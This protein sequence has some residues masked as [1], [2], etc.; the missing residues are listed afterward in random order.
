MARRNPQPIA[1]QKRGTEEFEES[2]GIRELD[3]ELRRIVGKQYEGYTSNQKEMARYFYREKQRFFYAGNVGLPKPTVESDDPFEREKVPN[4]YAGKRFT[5]EDFG[6]MIRDVAPLYKTEDTTAE[7]LVSR[8]RNREIN[9]QLFDERVSPKDGMVLDQ[10]LRPGDDEVF[11]GFAEREKGFYRRERDKIMEATPSEMEVEEFSEYVKRLDRVEELNPESPK[12]RQAMSGGGE[13]GESGRVRVTADEKKKMTLREYFAYEASQKSANTSKAVTSQVRQLEE[14]ID[15]KTKTPV[16]DMIVGDIDIGQVMGDVIS[17]SPFRDADI[18]A[19]QYRS[20]SSGLITRLNT[21]WSGAG[22]G[23]GYVATAVKDYLGTEDFE[24]ESGWRFKRGRKTPTQFPPDV[25]QQL[26]GILVD[27][28]IPY[29]ARL[30]LGGHLL[31]GLRPENIGSFTVKG[32]DKKNGLM[33]FY[34]AK[35]KKNKIIVLN[36]LAVDVINEAIRIQGD[37]IGPDGKIFPNKAKNQ[38][39]LNIVLKDRL[40]QV[41]FIR[42]DGSITPEDFTVYKLRNMHETLLTD[43]GGLE[44]GDVNFLNGRANANEAAGYV[45]EAARKR[46][47]DAA[48]KRV[49][50]AISGYMGAPSTAQL[51][52]NLNLQIGNKTKNIVVSADLLT[53]P[54]FVEAIPNSDKFIA[55]ISPDHGEGSYPKGQAPD[56][57]PRVTEAFNLEQIAASEDRAEGYRIATLEKRKRRIELE[58]EVDKI[59]EE[60]IR[61]QVRDQAEKKRIRDDEKAKLA[62][63]LDLSPEMD[64]AQKE[65]WRRLGVRVDPKTPAEDAPDAKP[66]LLGKAG[67][68]LKSINLPVVGEMTGLA[69]LTGS[70]IYGLSKPEPAF[71]MPPETGGMF[72]ETYP[73]SFQPVPAKKQAQYAGEVAEAIFSPL[74]M[75]AREMYE[76]REASEQVDIEAGTRMSMFPDSPRENKKAAPAPDDSF[77]TMSP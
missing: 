55:G 65:K 32:Y 4:P 45:S 28:E 18:E 34:D 63:N 38:R 23:Q 57:D 50:G 1:Q 52:A 72:E 12:F 30:Q 2:R 41:T 37:K 49:V 15:P 69:A 61:K 74:P 42:P 6:R 53:D 43:V 58:K 13:A 16:L 17:D 54:E 73:E 44:E 60:A 77:L 31:G 39:A 62:G 25:Y 24:T 67:K 46:R 20:R 35:S 11:P 21:M 66:G 7:G 3:K 8:K 14:I 64:E 9:E 51:G 36:P 27:K 68:V 48:N 10:I 76:Q 56:A 71:G 59:D 75:T 22:Y 47:I 19:T 40:D 29:E 5:D 33:T 26:Q 70:G